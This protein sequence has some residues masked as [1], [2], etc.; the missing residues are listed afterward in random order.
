MR[1]QLPAVAWKSVDCGWTGAF[2]DGRYGNGTLGSAV[3]EKQQAI[4]T[5]ASIQAL[6]LN[7]TEGDSRSHSLLGL[8]GE[9]GIGPTATVI[10]GVC[11]CL[12][13]ECPWLWTC[14]T[15]CSTGRCWLP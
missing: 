6:F 2:L 9:G 8:G 14:A 10:C 12:D 11:L 15:R 4:G 5:W 13:A 1:V 3:A 7:A